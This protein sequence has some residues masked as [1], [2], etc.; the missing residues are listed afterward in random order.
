[1]RFAASFDLA[2]G[3]GVL[4]TERKF[5]SHPMITALRS[6]ATV[7]STAV[8]SAFI[9]ASRAFAQESFGGELPDLEGTAESTDIKQTITNVLQYVLSFLALIA[10]IV[11]V[12]A[13]IRLIVSQGNEEER[14]KAKKTILYAVVGL[15]IVLFARVIVGFFTTQIIED[16]NIQ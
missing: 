9:T 12:I 11:I 15:L 16:A 14:D 10:V 1:M 6:S 3:V 8:V 7:V 4:N 5:P 2:Q 13:G